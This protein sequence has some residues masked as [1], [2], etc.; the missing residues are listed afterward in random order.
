MCLHSAQS[1]RVPDSLRPHGLQPPGSFVH[2]LSIKE[3]WSGLLFPL[4]GDLLDTGIELVS[5]ALVD[6]FFTTE[7]PGKSILTQRPTYKEEVTNSTCNQA[8]NFKCLFGVA[9]IIVKWA[10]MEGR[11]EKWTHIFTLFQRKGILSDQLLKPEQSPW[12]KHT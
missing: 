10:N 3:Y 8:L 12:K 9:M 2:G 6:G 4:P 1:L 7:M 5:P 11:R